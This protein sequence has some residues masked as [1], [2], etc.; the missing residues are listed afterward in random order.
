MK[1]RIRKRGEVWYLDQMFERTRFRESLGRGSKDWAQGKANERFRELL[2]AG[3]S[4][5]E[6]RS[7]LV[8]NDLETAWERYAKSA[9]IGDRHRVGSWASFRRL[10]VRSSGMDAD[11]LKLSDLSREMVEEY[12][13]MKL[14]DAEDEVDEDRKERS[15]C[16]DWRQAR[17]VIQSRALDF[18][19][20]RL[21]LLVPDNLDGLQG[22]RLPRPPSWQYVL[23]PQSLI[24]R[25]EREGS[26]LTGD[27]SL[28]YRMAINAGLRS[29]EMTFIT[30]DW[31]E[32][33][34]GQPVIAVVTRPGFRPKGKDRRVPI[35]ESLAADLRK[36][37]SRPIL[38]SPYKSYREEMIRYDFADWMRSIGWDRR[39]Y[40]K[41]AHELRKL[42]GSRIYT[43]KQLGPAYAQ[44]YLGHASIETTCRYYA[45]FDAP[46]IALPER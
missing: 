24:A 9:R 26:K 12:R 32:E 45:A 3:P 14:M 28:I 31:V 21:E 41:A 25:T 18:Y 7:A 46:L 44:Q 34:Q 1:A 36:F 15:A 30:G 2:I 5:K 38:S 10:F 11:R 37:G 29:G 40:S 20:R 16:S 33:V 8:L 43:N 13:E 27:L 19:R 17:S 22:F 23:P 4:V 6:R 39:Q 42:Y 35:P